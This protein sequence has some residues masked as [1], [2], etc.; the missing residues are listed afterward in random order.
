MCPLVPVLLGE[1]VERCAAADCHSGGHLLVE[2]ALPHQRMVRAAERAA[3]GGHDVVGKREDLQ[4]M[5]GQGLSN[6]LV[7]GGAQVGLLIED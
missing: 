6:L 3:P 5:G 1:R 7:L 2:T 4:A